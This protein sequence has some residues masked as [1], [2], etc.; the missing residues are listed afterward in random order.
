MLVS[1]FTPHHRS[2]K[3]IQ[4]AYDSLKRQVGIVNWEWVIL[5]NGDGKISAE[6]SKDKRIKVVE[7][8]PKETNRNIGFLKREAAMACSGDVLLELDDDDWLLS[9][10]LRVVGHNFES[11]RDLDFFYSSTIELNQDGTEHTY[12]PYWG[13]AEGLERDLVE[14]DR[15]IR[16]NQVFP[17]SPQNWRNIFWMPNHLRAWRAR[18][19]RELDGHNPDYATNDDQELLCRTFLSAKL[20]LHSSSPLYVQTIHAGNT[21]KDKDTNAKIQELNQ[22]LYEQYIWPMSEK[23]AKDE[24]LKLLDLGAKHGHKAGYVG[25]DILPGCDLQADLDKKW[26]FKDNSV[27]VIRAQ[28]FVEHIKD[29]IH[30]M[31]EAYRVLAPGGFLMI[32]VPSTDG[33]GAFQDPTHI[34]FWNSNS[35]WYYTNPDFAKFIPTFTGKFQAARINNYYPSDW[36][37]QHNIFY[38]GAQLMAVKDGWGYPG[39]NLW[40]E[41]ESKTSR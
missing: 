3:S 35:F 23:W 29:P 11:Y 22:S 41:Y 10:A 7:L 14:F 8:S 15:Q 21:Q 17:P 33:R 25:V 16:Y 19:Y 36:H 24:D 12:K 30:F 9:N 1:V 37:R 39:E 32:D 26:P 38:V 28:D 4:P 6:M 2:A 34:S 5:L 40:R 13:W 18:F 27:G 20:I 31:N